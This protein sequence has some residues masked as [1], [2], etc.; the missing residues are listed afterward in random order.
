MT[1]ES[2][3]ARFKREHG[4]RERR[5]SD[6]H[7]TDFPGREPVPVNEE[8]TPFGGNLGEQI[9]RAIA[10]AKEYAT[11]YVPL[12]RER[13]AGWGV[14]SSHEDHPGFSYINQLDELTGM[15]IKCE[16]SAVVVCH[17]L[18]AAIE[19]YRRRCGW[20]GNDIPVLEAWQATL[21]ALRAGRAARHE[22]EEW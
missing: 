18:G 11:V 5:T 3:L 17:H 6:G 16:C 19:A 15:P 2:N 10:R 7:L 13:G 21:D 9:D 8:T 1:V 14:S 12:W 20:Y 22:E 4:A